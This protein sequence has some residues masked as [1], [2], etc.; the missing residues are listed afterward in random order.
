ME[1]IN[2]KINKFNENVNAL[3]GELAFDYPNLTD[4]E[5]LKLSIGMVKNVMLDNIYESLNK[6][7]I[8]AECTSSELV[9]INHNLTEIDRSFDFLI[10]SLNDI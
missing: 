2:E 4:Y 8:N 7:A 6:I 1:T 3:S 5:I 10:K 9:D